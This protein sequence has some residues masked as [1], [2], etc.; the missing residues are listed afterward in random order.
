MAVGILLITHPGV[1][2]ALR[3]TAE[4][5]LGRL[6]LQIGCLEVEF[7]APLDPLLAAGSQSLRSLDE[8][9][10]VLLLTDVFGASPSNL[11]QRLTELGTATRRISG[12]NLPMLLRSLNYA[13]L[14]L[15]KLTE[16]AMSGGKLGV[17]V[18]HG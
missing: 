1:G 5:V 16:A 15:D 18:D 17:R 7:D 14:P 9:E 2:E 3:R 6:P 11:A 10:G 4:R 12:L 13:D 8:G